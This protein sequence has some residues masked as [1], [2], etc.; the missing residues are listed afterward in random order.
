M[1]AINVK[2]LLYDRPVLVTVWGLSMW[3]TSQN[4][5]NWQRTSFFPMKVYHRL[6]H[7]SLCS[8][9]GRVAHAWG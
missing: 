3:M 5:Q 7:C 9:N 6:T 8:L 4:K 2:T 1:L